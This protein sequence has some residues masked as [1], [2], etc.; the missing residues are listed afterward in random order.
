MKARTKQFV[1][2]MT[3]GKSSG[4]SKSVQ[5]PDGKRRKDF[6]TGELLAP[7]SVRKNKKRRT[8]LK[9][10]SKR[11]LEKAGVKGIENE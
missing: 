8:L 4:K 3:G 11:E 9:D 5:Y 7:R 2:K 10:C 6:I 1:E